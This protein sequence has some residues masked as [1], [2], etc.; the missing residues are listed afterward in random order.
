[1]LKRIGIYEIDAEVTGGYNDYVL[2]S[3]NDKESIDF[4]A[5][6][7]GIKKMFQGEMFYYA[8]LNNFLDREADFNVVGALN[9]KIYKVYFKFLDNNRSECI[10]FRNEIK[11]YL[12]E[13]MP[14]EIFNNPKITQI[15]NGRLILWVFDWGNILLEEIG[16]ISEMGHVMSTAI[17]ITSKSVCNAKKLS[18]FDRILNRGQ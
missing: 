7:C 14:P 8:R 9:N 16:V 2:E 1:M 12:S 6:K 10:S 15:K 13:Y 17:A 11:Q 18:F 5:A 4:L 3:I